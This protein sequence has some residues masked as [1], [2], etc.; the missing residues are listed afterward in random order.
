MSRVRFAFRSLV[1]APLLSLV[2]IL[3]VGL[4]IGA[5][6]AIFSL[7]HQIL[8]DRLPVQHPQELV[9]LTAPEEFKG[10]SSRTRNSGGME[11]IFSYPMFR[12]LEKRPQGVTAVAA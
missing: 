3:S 9:L 8:L 5:N 10:G 4:G 11:Y 6:T 2:V 12:E 7:L 1:K